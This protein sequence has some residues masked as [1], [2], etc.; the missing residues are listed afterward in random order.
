MA[1]LLP[2]L[3]RSVAK[4]LLPCQPR[5]AFPRI[6]PAEGSPK[7]PKKPK[8]P[9]SALAMEGIE[10]DFTPASI[11]WNALFHLTFGPQG[12]QPPGPLKNQN[13]P[14]QNQ[15]TVRSRPSRL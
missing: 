3:G 5:Q 11:D 14:K 15:N 2:P 9:K 7:T 8:N 10:K 1:A 4:S 13:K 6:Q 12:R